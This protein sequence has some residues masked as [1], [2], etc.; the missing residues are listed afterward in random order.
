MKEQDSVIIVRD[1]QIKELQGKIEALREEHKNTLIS[2]AKE[3]KVAKDSSKEV[4]SIS[5]E[6]L[7]KEKFKWKGLHLYGGGEVPSFDFQKTRLNTELMYEME[8]IE[9]GLK[10]ELLPSNIEAEPGYKFTYF[11]K[12]R[13][14]IF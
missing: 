3:N 2:I 7:K 4:D 10:G 11:L 12:V 14:K 1:Q 8:K 9:F 5:D 13:Y 6:Q